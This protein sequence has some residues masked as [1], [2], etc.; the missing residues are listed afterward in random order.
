VTAARSNHES[1]GDP[2]EGESILRVEAIDT[3]YGTSH[4]LHD[5]SLE[6]KRGETVALVGRNGAGKTTTLRSIMGLTPPRA[7]RIFFAGAKIQND[8]PHEIRKRGISWVPEDRRVFPNLSVAQNLEL[9]AAIG[10]G[11]DLIERMYERFE[12]LDERRDQ[13]AGTL[14]GGEQQ[15]LAIARALVGPERTCYSWTNRVRDSRHRSSPTFETSSRTSAPRGRLSSSS[16]RTPNSHSN[17]PTVRTSSRPGG[18]YTRVR[19]RPSS[20]TRRP[21]RRTSASPD[22]RRSVVSAS[23]HRLVVLATRVVIARH[24]PYQSAL[25]PL[26]DVLLFPD[27]VGGDRE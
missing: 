11:P 26:F 15:M 5:V 7:G 23:F 21:W 8:S 3:F 4:V 20:R 12:R 1:P 16:N 14:S 2:V 10:G 27:S 6:V 13:N 18:L 17:S 25:S 24:S 19:L 22:R 9:A